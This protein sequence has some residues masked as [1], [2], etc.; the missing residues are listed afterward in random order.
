VCVLAGG[1]QSRSLRP[2]S[3]SKIVKILSTLSAS[4]GMSLKEL[5]EVL[6]ISPSHCRE[7]IRFLLSLQL[8]TLNNDVVYLTDE[9]LVFLKSFNEGDV[10]FLNKVLSRNSVYKAVYECY[11][12]GFQK[13]SE[14]AKCAGVSL[15][16]SDIALRLI[17]EIESL[18]L[19]KGSNINSATLDLHVFEDVLVKAYMRL[20]NAKRSRYV[21]LSDIMREVMSKLKINEQQFAIMLSELVKK[22]RGYILLVSA[23]SLAHY[24]YLKIEG[25][26][27]THIMLAW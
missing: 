21:L 17:R 2:V 18:K 27:Y 11:R 22:K 24:S 25:K 1:G 5:A 14:I 15:V 7:A 12:K 23:P 9:G 4:N 8:I 19:H 26:P 3:L 16:S 20:M 6:R 13:A 10:D